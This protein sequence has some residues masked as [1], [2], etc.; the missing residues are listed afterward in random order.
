M[1][2]ARVNRPALMLYGGSIMPGKHEGRDITIVDV[3]EAVGARAAGRIDDDELHA[4]ECAACPG[5]GACGGQFTANTMATAFEAMGISPMG[6]NS[7]P[8]ENPLKPEVARA[9]GRLVLDL[10]AGDV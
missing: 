8:A 6:A 9:C 2:L 5:A 10:V 1:A 7:V 4:I 3:F